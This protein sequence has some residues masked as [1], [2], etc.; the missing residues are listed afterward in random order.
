MVEHFKVKRNSAAR[1]IVAIILQRDNYT[2]FKC[3]YK[4][5]PNFKDKHGFWKYDLVVDHVIPI[6]LGG[7][8]TDEKNLWTLCLDCNWKKNCKDQSLIAQQKRF[9]KR[10]I[11]K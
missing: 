5:N 3:G 7:K 8:Q 1:K 9:D 6:S 2:C 11:N 10:T 4:H